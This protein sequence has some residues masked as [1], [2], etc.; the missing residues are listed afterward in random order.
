MLS[1]AQAA[2]ISL[3]RCMNAWLGGAGVAVHC[4][5][6]DLTPAGGVGRTAATIFATEDGL[7]MEEWLQRRFRSRLLE[8]EELGAAVV[9]L[10]DNPLATTGSSA[11]PG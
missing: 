5:C 2:I 10:T 8:P 7:T 9:E 1:P 4:L 6:P 3:S 11:R